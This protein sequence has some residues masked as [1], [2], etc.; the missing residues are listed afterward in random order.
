MAK[1]VSLDVFDAFIEANVTTEVVDIVHLFMNEDKTLSSKPYSGKIYRVK[2]QEPGDYTRYG[3][4][5]TI[6]GVEKTVRFFSKKKDLDGTHVKDI[7]FSVSRS[8]SDKGK[9]N[10]FLWLR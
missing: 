10:T 6:N 8:T 2:G 1:K 5:A 3:L 7:V 9:V 4:V